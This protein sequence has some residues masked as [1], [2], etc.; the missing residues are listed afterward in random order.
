[1]SS[2][3]TTVDFITGN[4]SKSLSSKNIYSYQVNKMNLAPSHKN[5]NSIMNKNNKNNLKKISNESKYHSVN[6][7]KEIYKHNCITKRRKRSHERKK[8]NLMLY[9]NKSR[10]I[11]T[12]Q[13]NEKDDLIY[14]LDN[15]KTKYKNQENKFK[16]QQK[17]MKSEIEILREKLKALSVNEAL[18]Q[19]EIEKLKRKNSEVANHLKKNFSKKNWMPLSKNIIIMI[20]IIFYILFRKECPQIN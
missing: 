2:T 11:E 20:I 15:I 10:P 14:L 13:K 3:T 1:M 17:N 16:N 8:T 5:N 18:Y 4:N 6:E 12:N 7:L 9:V 19:V